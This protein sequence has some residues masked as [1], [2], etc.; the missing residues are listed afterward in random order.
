MN[1]RTKE[2]MKTKL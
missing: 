2:K 1:E